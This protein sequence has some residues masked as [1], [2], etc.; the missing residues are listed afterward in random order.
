M[1]YMYFLENKF[2]ADFLNFLH[3][4]DVTYHIGSREDDYMNGFTAR[5]L[6]LLESEYLYNQ[7]N[8]NEFKSNVIDV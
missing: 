3:I 8:F 5:M 4:G 6:L 7:E 2:F 1:E